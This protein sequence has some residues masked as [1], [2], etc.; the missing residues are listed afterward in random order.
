MKKSKMKFA[1]ILTALA[2]TMQSIGFVT[3]YANPIDENNQIEIKQEKEIKEN[4][5][6]KNQQ[7]EISMQLNQDVRLIVELQGEPVIAKAINQ[8]IS[9]SELTKYEIEKSEEKIN[10]EQEQALEDL[11]QSLPNL[12]ENLKDEQEENDI[13]KYNT[14]FNGLAMS[15]KA[16]D[17]QTIKNKSYVKNVYI[18]EEYERPQM[19]HSNQTIG[20]QYV[21]DTKKYKGEGTVVAIDVLQHAHQ[22]EIYGLQMDFQQF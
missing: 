13:I 19:K 5:L 16:E 22:F 18:S 10:L 2:L 17:I 1:C 7:D 12:E 4:E 6:P 14:S 11:K 20:S 3:V 15:V 9:Y 8:G 21:W